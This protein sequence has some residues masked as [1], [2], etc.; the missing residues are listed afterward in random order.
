MVP[1]TIN[2][3]IHKVDPNTDLRKCTSLLDLQDLCRQHLARIHEAREDDVVF[4]RHIPE[5][6]AA[7][8]E[9]QDRIVVELVLLPLEPEPV[10]LFDLR[11]HRL[12]REVRRARHIGIKADLKDPKVHWVIEISNVIC[13]FLVAAATVT[14]FA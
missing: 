2:S 9:E 8:R 5:L 11:Q 1:G 4:L 6:L 7:L 10:V 14:L 13:Q 3:E 12:V